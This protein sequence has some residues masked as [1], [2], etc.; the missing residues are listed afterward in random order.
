MPLHLLDVVECGNAFIGIQ[1]LEFRQSVNT[2]ISITPI[3]SGAENPFIT[4]MLYDYV[5]PSE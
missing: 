1:G 3:D 5:C 2:Q 4:G